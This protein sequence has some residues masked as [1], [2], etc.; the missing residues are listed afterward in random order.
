MNDMKY[1]GYK[2][3]GDIPKEWKVVKVKDVFYRKKAKAYQT[4]PVILSLARSG[5][6]IRDISNNEGQI[7]SSYFEYNPVS[8]NDMLINPMDLQSGANCSISLVEGVISPAYI[9]LRC[10]KDENPLFF[11]YYFKY[12]YW[13]YAFFAHGKGV[14]FEN[15]W[16]LNED[17]LMNFPLICPSIFAQNRI[18]L[19]LSDTSKKIDETLMLL[20]RQ[21][22]LLLEY[23]KSF[24]SEIVTKGLRSREFKQSQKKY[25]GE[26][27]SHWKINKVKFYLR[28]RTIKNRPM[29]TVL[30]LYR[31]YGVIP[32]DSRDD[33][34]NV[35]AED[36]S[37]YLVIRPGD[38]VINKMK[39]W[40]GSMA[41]S[42]YEGIISPAYYCFEFL[43]GTFNKKYFHYLMRNKKYIPEFRRLSAGI[44]EG[45]WDLS[46]DAFKN[47]YIVIPPIEEQDEIVEYLDKKCRQV[48][49]IIEQKKKQ[50]SVLEE[51]KKSLI[52]EYVTGKK[53]VPNE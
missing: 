37:K 31:E 1:S 53:E 21:I 19:F 16:T 28:R 36:T 48:D 13:S 34:H 2:W 23:K 32:K 43:D 49:E 9:N 29:L 50:I 25:L 22:N 24:I 7:A 5:V 44:R 6:K 35:T 51:Y 46:E 20:E 10:K 39:A 4:D 15:R 40:Q 12:Q 47:I 33:N 38:F 42:E 11:D 26:V 18:A 45:Q 8:I 52:Y 30:S 17:T 41:V 27:P 3:L 14:S